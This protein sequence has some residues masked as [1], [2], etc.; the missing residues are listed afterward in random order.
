VK[1]T[2]E[3]T[4]ALMRDLR[5]RCDW[6]AAQ[7]HQ[8]LR[9][10]LIEEA[11]E[12]DEALLAGDDPR[13]RE[14]LGDLLLQILFHS[15][16]AEERGAF[17]LHD[18]AESFVTKMKARHPHLYG[19]G[20][21]EPWERM[22]AK[23]RGSLT[24]GLPAGLPSL[25]RAFRLQDRAAGVGFDWPNTEGPVEKVREELSE[26]EHELSGEG[27]ASEALQDEIGDLLFAVV[28]L[29]RKAG[30]HPALALDR[31]NRKFE[32]RFQGIE[33]RAA[34][35]GINVADAGLAVLDALWD[36]VKQEEQD[37]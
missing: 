1:P 6:D 4:L 3:D 13:L 2:L 22:K 26:V 35:R 24:E 30:V 20:V 11:H 33:R 18:V 31:A 25:H 32:R 7:T 27:S 29:A 28:N 14:E 37:E 15:V 5:R 16:I 19:D 8:S 9:P 36:E 21:R 34:E 17:G 10:Y 23:K 12:V